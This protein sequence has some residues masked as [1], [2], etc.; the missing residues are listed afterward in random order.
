[1]PM[2]TRSKPTKTPTSSEAQ[3][4]PARTRN[5]EADMRK[6]RDIIERAKAPTAKKIK[7]TR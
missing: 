5:S 2:A 7:R 6:L 1:M 4:A 3:K